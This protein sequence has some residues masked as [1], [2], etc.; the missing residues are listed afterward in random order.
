[1]SENN[2]TQVNENESVT[3]LDQII[4]NRKEKLDK[5]R[6]AGLNPYPSGY[7]ANTTASEL[8]KRFAE[9]K[10]GEKSDEVFKLAGRLVS[11]REMGKASFAD[12]LDN[13]GKLQF[14]IRGDF[15]GLESYKL[16][17]DLIDLSDFIGIEGTPFRTRTGELSINVSS[18][19]LLSKALRPL[20]GK[21]ARFKRY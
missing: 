14:Y 10:T 5:L 9:L 7:C 11:R 20:P 2:Q 21:M 6:Q 18:W 15:V 3:P 13:S 19:T 16:F 8:N 1:M 4:A 12:I 17:K